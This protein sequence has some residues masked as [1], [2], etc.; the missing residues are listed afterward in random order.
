MGVIVGEASGYHAALC[1]AH[2]RAREVQERPQL[3]LAWH[4]KL[5]RDLCTRHPTFERFIYPPHILRDDDVFLLGHRHVAHNAVQE[6]LKFEQQFFNLPV[7]NLG[8]RQ[9]KGSARLFYRTRSPNE[10]N[11][12]VVNYGWVS[13][14]LTAQPD[15]SVRQ[16]GL[17]DVQLP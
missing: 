16:V 9:P 14:D 13:S 7:T 12:S 11:H 6:S 17:L 1:A 10:I 3:A 8:T 5:V 15:K 2:H 4:H